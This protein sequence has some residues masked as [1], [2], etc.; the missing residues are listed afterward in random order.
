[1]V[2]E[3][4]SLKTDEAKPGISIPPSQ[5]FERICSESQT[6]GD[7]HSSGAEAESTRASTAGC[8]HECEVPRPGC[9]SIKSVT[10]SDQVL[11]VPSTSINE[12]GT[13]IASKEGLEECQ[14]QAAGE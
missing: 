10:S 7:V 12:N 4:T 11:H 1:M 6:T 5:S 8:P 2:G 9:L 13:V 14:S 3:K